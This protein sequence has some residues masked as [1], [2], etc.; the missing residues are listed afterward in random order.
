MSQTKSKWPKFC[1]CGALLV[2][3]EEVPKPYAGPV[4]HNRMTGA[5]LMDRGVR[6]PKSRGQL[7]DE[8]FDR[9]SN[10]WD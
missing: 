3:F 5:V 6:C 7:H 9:D 8:Y 2:P 10:G 4:E 1:N